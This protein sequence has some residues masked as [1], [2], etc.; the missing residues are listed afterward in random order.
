MRMIA[1]LASA[2]LALG[3]ATSPSANA[4]DARIWVSLGDVTFSAGLPYHRQHH[5]PLYREQGRHGPRYY[6]YA[7]P[8][9]PMPHY[10]PGPPYGPGYGYY[11]DARYYQPAPPPPPRP[12][13][14]YHR[15]RP[16]Y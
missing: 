11:Y 10:R 9:R 8:V 7:A 16:G 5:Y 15:H 6:Y 2:A 13:P 14:G 12:R 4:H 3:L 1:F